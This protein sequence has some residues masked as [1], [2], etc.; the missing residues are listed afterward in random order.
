MPD[1]G[2]MQAH[3]GWVHILTNLFL[4]CVF[5]LYL[6]VIN[7]PKRVMVRRLRISSVWDR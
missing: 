1:P 6:E 4:Q 5:G 3:D 7:G 2:A